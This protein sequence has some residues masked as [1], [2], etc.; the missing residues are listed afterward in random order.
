MTPAVMRL[1]MNGEV[2]IGGSVRSQNMGGVG[3]AYGPDNKLHIRMTWYDIIEDV[4]REATAEIDGFDLP[5]FGDF[6]ETAN[7]TF[8]YGPGADVQVY[9]L[10]AH[11]MMLI[12]Q[13]RIAEMQAIPKD[14]DKDRLILAELC[15]TPLLASDP[16]AVELKDWAS[17]DMFRE[18]ALTLRKEMLARGE[19]S[20]RRCKG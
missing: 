20:T 17:L 1:E 5:T 19:V 11:L 4:T 12:G 7:L 13:R 6:G 18:D 14:T 9:S 15:G 16:I 2:M 3:V 8:T 10:N